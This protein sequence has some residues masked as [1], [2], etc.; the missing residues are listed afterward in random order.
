MLTLAGMVPNPT[1][2][3]H[4]TH[5]ENLPGILARGGICCD[6]QVRNGKLAKVDIGNPE[7][8]A[9]RFRVPLRVGPGGVVA[10][11]VPFYFAPRSPMLFTIHKGGVPSYK[12]GQNDV[13]YLV[14]SAQKIASAPLPFVFTDGHARM[15]ISRSFDDLAK[16]SEIDW[17][18]MNA[19]YWN[20]A[21]EDPDR[22]RRRQAEILVHSFCPI[23]QI[24]FIAV[25]NQTAANNAKAVAESSRIA[26]GVRVMSQ[27]YFS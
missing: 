21:Q 6:R 5:I 17:P 9:D 1:L 8:K 13:L 2:I 24:E 7:I 11:Y 25:R 18:L 12:E 20:D 27:W 15:A 16:L 19:K 23:N 3:F 14:S 22:K 4:M 26:P 10:D